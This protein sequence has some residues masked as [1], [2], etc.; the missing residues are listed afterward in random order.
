[1]N[2]GAEDDDGNKASVQP[3]TPV[4]LDSIPAIKNAYAS[5]KITKEKA[6]ELQ[7]ALTPTK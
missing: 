1:V 4:T 3:K 5:G 7:T 6:I 2:V